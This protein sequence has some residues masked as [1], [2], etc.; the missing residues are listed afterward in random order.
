MDTPQERL[1]AAVA[2]VQAAGGTVRSVTPLADPADVHTVVAHWIDI[3][4]PDRDTD[5]AVRAALAEVSV[6]TAGLVPWVDPTPPADVED[7]A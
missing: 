3:T 5:V 1:D 2:A 6:P 7:V 4:S